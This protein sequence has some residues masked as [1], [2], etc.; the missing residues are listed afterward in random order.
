[1]EEQQ[2]KTQCR[3][4]NAGEQAKGKKEA[5]NIEQIHVHSTHAH[6]TQTDNKSTLRENTQ[7]EINKTWIGTSAYFN[8]MNSISLETCKLFVYH[9]DPLVCMWVLYA[10]VVWLAAEVNTHKEM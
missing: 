9:S 2:K 7:N 5:T 3:R 6:C 8:R 1:M 10:C 4:T